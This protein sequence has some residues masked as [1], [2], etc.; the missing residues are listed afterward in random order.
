V[1][2]PA[3]PHTLLES[4]L[5]GYVQGA[6]TDAKHTKQGRFQL[7]DTGTIFLDE[8]GDLT[9]EIQIKLL[10]VLDERQ[11]YPLGATEPVSVDVKVIAATNQDLSEM[12][13]SGKFRQDLYYRLKVVELT[14]PSLKER[15]EDIALL[16]NH[17]LT[18]QA[19]A[20]GKRSCT[21]NLDVMKILLNYEYPG[22]VRELQHIIEHMTILCK[23]NEI[24]VDALPEY[25][26]RQG[27]HELS[28]RGLAGLQSI[29]VS[30]LEKEKQIISEVLSTQNWHRDKAAK[31]LHIDRTTLWRKMKKHGLLPPQ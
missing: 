10:Q 5:F 30:F 15:R 22:N 21:L 19:K 24:G 20:L 12:V 2:C 8:I 28:I 13:Q 9:K 3:L 23:K 11:F 16:I 26:I 4:E 6:F 7:A 1:N 17:F 25:L 31:A 14:I 29:N 18:K 27:G